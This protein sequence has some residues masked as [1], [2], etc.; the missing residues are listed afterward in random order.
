MNL[1]LSTVSSHIETPP[2]YK[3]VFTFSTFF[4]YPRAFSSSAMTIFN[5]LIPAHVLWDLENMRQ[6][7]TPVPAFPQHF[8]YGIFI[9]VSICPGLRQSLSVI[10]H[11]FSGGFCGSV[12]RSNLVFLV[13]LY[14]ENLT[15]HHCAP[16]GQF[17]LQ[18]Y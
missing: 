6:V 15:W 18:T 17:L 13:D 5:A 7:H 9:L 16:L 14:T 10:F 8:V 2:F 3:T 1:T 12:K 11:C 4:S